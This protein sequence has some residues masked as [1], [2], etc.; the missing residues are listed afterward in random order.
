MI[1]PLVLGCAGPRLSAHERDFFGRV[2]PWGFI[3]FARNIE[4]PGQLR[5]LTESLRESVGRAD[6][7]VF[8]DQEGGRVQR[9]GPPHWPKRPAASVFA[10]LGSSA[11]ET[12][13]AAARLIADDLRAVGITVDCLPVLDVPTAGA[14]PIIGDRAYGADPDTVARLGRAAADGLLAGGVLPVIKHVPG[15]GR[16][17]VDSHLTL[18]R[19]EASRETLEQWDFAPFRALR[20]FPVAMTAHVLYAAIDAFEPATTSVRVIEDVIRG[21]IGFEGLL[22][23]DDIGMM[24]LSGDLPGR[25]RRSLEAGC[26]VVLHCSGVLAEMEAVAG[27][28]DRFSQAGERRAAAALACIAG[29]PA[30]FDRRDAEGRLRAALEGAW[31]A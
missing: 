7:P 23:S 30:F 19:V 16:A 3:V 28:A 2:E 6:A 5:A 20:D 25:A 13:F 9:L 21:D 24:A 14:D 15:H 17:G 18:P 22:I 4:N 8:V 26:D 29:A 31:V 11:T 12:T 10:A 1:A 27:A